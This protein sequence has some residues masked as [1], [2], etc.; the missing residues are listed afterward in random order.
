MDYTRLGNSG[1]KVSRLCLGMMSYGD[2]A[3]QEWALAQD[4]AEPLVRRA[5]D[6]GVTFFDTADVYSSGASEVVTG[7]VLRAIFPRREDYVLATKVYFPMGRG[8]N[9]RGLSRKHILD[10]V[11]ASLARLGTDYV[12][13]YQI[14]RWDD[15]TPIEET[16]EALHDVVRA[17]KARYIGASSMWA[18]QFAKA[19]HA[20]E[21]NGWTKFVSMQNHYNLLFREEEREML[22]LCADQGVGVIPW[23]PLARGVLARAGSA[24]ATAR[25]GSDER[26]DH[27]YDPEN[28]K[29]IV[30]R[31]ARVAA[32]RALPAA[33]IALAWVLRRAGVT[34][35][36]VGA[37]KERHVD[38]A[39]AALS[40]SLSDEE[41]AFLEEPYRPREV[42][43]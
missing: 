35:P 8:R 13:L 12:D 18:W 38:D 37:T 14:H 24:A 30:D 26:I 16:M 2:P 20:A 34:A 27:L 36:I 41:A 25:T 7:N 6:A 1:L 17:G 5:A 31:V 9:D 15:T 42:R 39:V 40:V 33:Q 3:R 32:D 23:S 10:A 11:D 21:V 29:L 43:F 19:Q 28:D 22:P 4:A